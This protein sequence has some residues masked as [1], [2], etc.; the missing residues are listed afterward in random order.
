MTKSEFL[1]TFPCFI[2]A[3]Q[4]E[5]HQ[6]AWAKHLGVRVKLRNPIGMEL[7]LIPPGEFVMGSP[8]FE[9][10]RKSDETQHK[11]TLTKP[12]FMG[13]TEVT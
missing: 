6:K 1:W 2:L 7:M 4:A 12:F 8:G 11:V 3:K 5:E 13:V 10:G 9:D